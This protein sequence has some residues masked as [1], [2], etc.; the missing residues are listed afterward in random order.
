MSYILALS[1]GPVQEFIAAARKT[2]DL[3]FGSELLS[4][5]ARAAALSLHG[6]RGV[7]LVFPAP[8]G[9]RDDAYAPVPNKI[10]AVVDGDPA[11]LAQHARDA[12]RA[13]L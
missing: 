10:V 4:R 2:R 1:L 12:A 13:Y 11:A 3:W 6:Q 8:D 5:T 7:D 9:L